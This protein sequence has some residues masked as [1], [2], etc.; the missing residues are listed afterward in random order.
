[1]Y[2][3]DLKVFEQL[4]RNSEIL[5]A[6]F[7]HDACNVCQV[8]RP[9]VKALVERLVAVDFFYVNTKLNPMIS[10]QYMVFAV[11]TLLI[12]VRGSEVKRFSRYFS[13]EDIQGVLNRYLQV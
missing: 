2:N 6:Y 13:I 5:V 3:P 10:G 8:L 12:F 7:S 4:R 1:M 11:P 9:K